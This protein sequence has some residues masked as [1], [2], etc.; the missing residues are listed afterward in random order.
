[1]KHQ[2]NKPA[3]VFCLVLSALLTLEVTSFTLSYYA[4]VS[5]LKERDPARAATPQAQ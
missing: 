5:Y 3:R 1:M 4:A 2:Y